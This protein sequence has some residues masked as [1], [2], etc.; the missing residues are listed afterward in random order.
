MELKNWDFDAIKI[1]V[2]I[3]GRTRIIDLGNTGRVSPNIDITD[4]IEKNASGHPDPDSF[5]E[6]ASEFLND[7]LKQLPT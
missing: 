2:E 3:N 1:S 7:F 5:N 4:E 6:L